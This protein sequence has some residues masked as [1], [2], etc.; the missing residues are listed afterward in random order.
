[1]AII[2]R[3]GSFEYLVMPFGLTNAPAT[4]STLMND[5]FRH[6]LDSCIVVYLDDILVYSKCLDEHRAHLVEVFSIL[7]SNQLY[8]KKEKCSFVQQE[9]EFLGHYVGHGKLWP[10]LEK[11]KVI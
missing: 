10:D 5:I 1:M 6:M 7:R 4:F 9:I 2:M 3:Y 11:L 8:A